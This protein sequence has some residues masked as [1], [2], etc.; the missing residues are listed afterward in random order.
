MK[1][2]IFIPIIL[3]IISCDQDNDVLDENVLSEYLESN[4]SRE[5]AD[6]VACA[7][8]KEDGLLGSENE[9][10][11]VFFYPIEGATEFRYFEAENVA[12]STDFSKYVA[13]DLRS[14][15]IFNGYLWKFN[16]EPFSGSD[17][18][19]VVTYKT[20]GKIHVCTPIRQKTNTKP[21]EVNFEL[22]RF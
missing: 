18:M 14:E 5:L 3:L 22:G 4:S 12:D 19:G 6:L 10:T 15:P 2:L 16:N 21:T 8:G 11:D 13:K 17:R 9:P 7:G 1:S 20:P